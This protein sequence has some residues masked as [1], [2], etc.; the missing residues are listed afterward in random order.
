MENLGNHAA[1]ANC[2]GFS[3]IRFRRKSE[4]QTDALLRFTLL[5]TDMLSETGPPNKVHVEQQEAP[6]A[7]GGRRD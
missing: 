6:E 7:Q 1:R 4:M 5:C 2:A 3:Q